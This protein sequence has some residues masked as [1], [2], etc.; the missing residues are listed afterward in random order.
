MRSPAE[1][2]ILI[3]EIYLVLG[4]LS[5]AAFVTV[6]VSRVVPHA[7]HITLAAR[8]LILP[9]SILLWPWILRRWLAAR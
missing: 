5:A 2:I 1:T 7:G 3:L 4:A 9:A 6:G 8:L